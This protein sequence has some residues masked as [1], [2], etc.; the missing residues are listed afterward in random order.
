MFARRLVGGGAEGFYSPIELWYN[1]PSFI[2]YYTPT[3]SQ[4]C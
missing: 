3:I 2:S 1:T 4:G